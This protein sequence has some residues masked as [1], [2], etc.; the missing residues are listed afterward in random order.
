MKPAVDDT[1]SVATVV[2]PTGPLRTQATLQIKNPSETI[3]LDSKNMKALQPKEEVKSVKKPT[4]PMHVTAVTA[5]PSSS[6][7]GRISASSVP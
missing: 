3:A 1:T 5:S 6:P 4:L 7:K 2:D